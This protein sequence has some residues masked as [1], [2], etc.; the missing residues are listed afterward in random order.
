[1]NQEA[2]AKEKILRLP[3]VKARTG[4][5]RSTIYALIA[6]NDFPRHVPLG[7]RC[8]GWLE[9]EI[10]SWI[11]TRVGERRQLRVARSKDS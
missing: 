4:L 9:S 8:V 3:E 1:M 7:M 2:N 5:S 6:K 11:A 10:D